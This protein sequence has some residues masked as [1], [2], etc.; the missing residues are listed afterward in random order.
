MAVA[1]KYAHFQ[2]FNIPIEG[3]PEDRDPDFTSEEAERQRPVAAANRAPAKAPQQAAPVVEADSSEDALAGGPVEE[4][5]RK[6]IPS[7][8]SQQ[9]ARDKLL[10]AYGV[11]LLDDIADTLQN[12]GWYLQVLP[13]TAEQRASRAS[14]PCKFW[15]MDGQSV[16]AISLT[17]IQIQ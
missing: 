13:T 15:Y 16:Q 9:K 14:P 1:H 3:R 10:D 12:R 4:H 5:L 6:I 11:M 2:L 7:A 8:A 17:S